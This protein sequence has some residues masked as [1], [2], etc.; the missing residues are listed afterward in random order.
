LDKYSIVSG[1]KLIIFYL[2][3][4]DYFMFENLAG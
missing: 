1:N 4:D 2:L 3:I